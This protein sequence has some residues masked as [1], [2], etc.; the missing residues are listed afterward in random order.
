MQWLILIGD[1]NFNLNI[2]K[3]IKHK[4]YTRFYDVPGIKGRYCVEFEQEHIFYD[5]D[6]DVGELAENLSKV[7]YK[8][9][10]FIMMIYKSEELVKHILK[11]KDFPNTIYVDN[12]YGLVLP[13][14]EFI[15]IGMPLD[16]E[17]TEDYLSDSDNIIVN[18]ILDY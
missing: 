15:E 5:F 17:E 9:P 18:E 1:E 2:L 13:L 6:L 7:P 8:K 10:H 16:K 14:K 11:L 4:G 12:D 3:S